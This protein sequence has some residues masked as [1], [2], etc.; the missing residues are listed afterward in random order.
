MK[1]SFTLL[2]NLL[3]VVAFAQTKTLPKS[4]SYNVVN[5][6]VTIYSTAENSDLRITQTGVVSFS[7]YAQPVEGELSIFVDPT[8]L[9]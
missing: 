4:P 5:K 3:V 7:D 8:V 1:R 9:S 6:K 2:L